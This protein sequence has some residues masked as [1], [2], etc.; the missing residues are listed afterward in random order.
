MERTWGRALLVAVALLG[1][2][3]ASGGVGGGCTGDCDGDKAVGI[4][5]LITMVNVALGR[6]A[7]PA[8]P[9]GDRD[10]D[11]TIA[12]DELVRAVGHALGECEDDVEPRPYRT[13]IDHPSDPYLAF[14]ATPDGPSWV[15]FTIRVADPS[16]VY[17]QNSAQIPLHHD[18]VSTTLAP[19]IG[20]T[21]AEIDAVSLHA[22]GQELV[23]GAVLYSPT[24]PHEI[25]IQLVRQD[26]YS[27][28]EVVTYF[29]AARAAVRAADGV[30][31]FYFPTFEQQESAEAHRAAL[32]A[33]GIPLGSTARWAP[34]D[35]C[36][37]P[38]WAHGRVVFVA[39]ADIADAY[40]SGALGP[41]DILLTDG[42]PAEIPYVAGV[43]S[44]APSTPSSHVAVLANDWGTP[45][46]FLSTA[47]SAAAA[48]ALVGR[49]VV[50]RATTRTPRVDTGATVDP[51]VCEIRLEDVTGRLDE[52]VAA[53]LRALKRAPDLAIRPFVA[54]GT[55]VGEVDTATPDDVVTIGG[56][57]SNYGFLRR[58]IPQNAR[59]A[60]AFTF[61]LWNDY[62]DQPIAGGP[63]LRERIATLLAPFPTYPPADF[64]ALFEALDA[65]R[66]L[67]D[68]EGEFTPAQRAVVLEALQRFDPDLP[69]RFRSSTNVED[70]EVFTGAGLYESESGCL[71][72]ELDG[73]EQ[74][75][76]RCDA[77]RPNER[78]VFRALRKVFESFYNDNAFLERLRHRVDERTV[79][80]AVLVHH[81][82]T[83]DTE[84]ANGVATLRVSGP[85]A[86]A[87][88]V[89]QPGAYS[90]TNPEDDGIP[91]VVEV[92]AYGTSRIPTLRQGAER[93]PLGTTVLA[94]PGE[95][96][97]L[98]R[99]LVLVG[100]A[101]G[102]FHGETDFTI[103]FEYKKIAGEGLE[104][105]QVRRIP[106]AAAGDGTPVLIDS[107]VELCTFQGERSDV[108]ADYRLK[109]RWQ[110]RFVSGPVAGTGAL[111]AAAPHQYVAD[112]ALATLAGAPASW[113]DA[114]H[115]SFDP[116]VA[117]VL[118]IS[119]AW[120]IGDGG[121]ARRMTL[122]TFVPTNVG[123]TGIPIVFPEDLGFTLEADFA[124]PVPFL[125]FDGTP[126]LRSM[127]Q[128]LLTPCAD[129]R[130]LTPRHTRQHRGVAEAGVEVSTGFYW[131]P[132]PGG[133][134][135]GYTAPL[136]RW[137]ET[138]VTGVGSSPVVLRG[139]FSQTYRPEHHNF[140]ENF[141]FDP[142][143]EPDIDAA[144]LADW[145]AR[146]I[147]ALILPAYHQPPLQ[148]LT[149]DGRIVPLDAG[150]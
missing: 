104:V 28:D 147:R 97:E 14:S 32:A 103:E 62:L 84:L 68:D 98:T 30:P 111:Y 146:G 91:E 109:S 41:D 71:A 121:S 144:T 10:G 23:F 94:L 133:A 102:A 110:P 4:A 60:I 40:E 15:K 141:V 128:V 119:D 127:E 126:A 145:D 96:A 38:G 132:E 82:F 11:G 1:A 107:P 34:G 6:A 108:L 8:C 24:T 116:G 131:P 37:A 21:P 150:P 51:A 85:S 7:L 95:Y 27:V 81:T 117:G 16:L 106:T 66:D 35:V 69:I 56:K 61:D 25:A 120:R 46:A 136:D 76:S 74:G 142:H 134:V 43:L 73:D 139:Y 63:T 42:V 54:A 90:V 57:A 93:L 48:Q 33:A 105:K 65:V 44:L 112:G 78:G 122:R 58:A 137:V 26:A 55:S 138:T 79:G 114:A 2:V 143:L 45:F 5:E 3:P 129:H 101:F 20:W 12:I 22:E 87:T 88:I 83:D 52:T 64:A 135:A 59:P 86:V 17:F 67:I 13:S 115:A 89:S 18:F 92:F 123:P 130:A 9:N 39:G 50:L 149:L 49:E 125:D 31:F 80:M 99:L 148:A 140:S 124:A 36:Y 100:N 77:T 19:Y 118:G 70:S 47:E 113:A 72:D 29:R 75:P 53:H